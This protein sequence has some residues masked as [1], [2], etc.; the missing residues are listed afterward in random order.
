[1]HQLGKSNLTFTAG[2][3][4]LLILTYCPTCSKPHWTPTSSLLRVRYPTPGNSAI[5]PS[6][7]P[8]RTHIH[9]QAKT[10]VD[11]RNRSR[12]SHPAIDA[13]SAN[14]HVGHLHISRL[15]RSWL[16]SNYKKIQPKDDV[17]QSPLECATFSTRRTLPHSLHSVQ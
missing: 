10:V 15:T 2:P 13:T 17:Q 9:L 3:Q 6:H 11:T 14:T 5:R 7:I 1:V 12:T 16:D 4:K 8:T